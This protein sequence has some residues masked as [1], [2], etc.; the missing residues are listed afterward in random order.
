MIWFTILGMSIITFFNRFIFLA[1]GVKYKV[2]ERQKRFLGFSGLA[3]LTAI[4]TPI[5]F[6]VSYAEHV[7][8]SAGTDYLLAACV[9]GALSLS[10]VSSL[11]VV[12]LSTSLFFVLRS[13]VLP[14]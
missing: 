4:W 14:I 2:G 6:Q 3:V 11:Y 5:V 7:Q 12:V 8:I 13:F 9:A 10:K 1:K